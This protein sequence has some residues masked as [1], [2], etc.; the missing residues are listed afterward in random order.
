MEKYY[1]NIDDIQGRKY[2]RIYTHIKNLIIEGEIKEHEKLPPIRKLSEYIGVNNTTIVKVYELLEKEG[3]VY[4]IVGSG[5]FASEIKKYRAKDE[6]KNKNIIQFDN[7]NPSNEMFPVEDFKKAVNL[8]LSKNEGAIFE[9]DEGLGNEGL[10]DRI[11]KYLIK[12]GINAAKD[13]LQIISGAQQGIDIVCKGIINYSDIVFVEEPTYNGAIEVFKSRGAKIISIPMLDDGIDI[14]I[15]KLKLDKI[16]PKL[17]YVMP[18]FQNPT[19]ISYSSYKKKKLLEL[20]EEYD[21][22]ILEDDFI[23]DFKFDS[24]DN[25]PLKSYDENNRV[26]Y[27]K[28]FSKIFM[29]GLR[30]GVIDIPPEL[31]KNILWAKYSSDISTPGLIQSSLLCY[32]E[33]FDW[34]KHIEKMD[35]IYDEKYRV[36]KECIKK[37]FKG[38]IRVRNC[39]GGI[40]FFCELPRGCKSREFTDFIYKKGVSVL[41]GTYFYDN[42]IDDRFFRINVAR[43]SVENI[44]KGIEIIGRS[45]EEFLK[46]NGENEAIMDNRL[47][48]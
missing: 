32:M 9:Y 23:S 43:E 24:E 19:G 17:M 42:V 6:K 8:A 3:Y 30:I 14:G 22:Y 27:I 31:M 2:I 28:S 40:N 37:F 36:A 47:F 13:D 45:V 44:E 34:D 41:P 35:K 33:E 38:R 46:N 25:R 18:N 16:K 15:L 1:L 5:T 20:A 12:N 48:Y 11:S 39:S 4:K 29:P 10:R 7:G 26:I 21:F